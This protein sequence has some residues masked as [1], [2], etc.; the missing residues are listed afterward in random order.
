MFD[1]GNKNAKIRLSN[2][3]FYDSS[4]KSVDGTIGA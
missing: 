1:K 3:M 2:L 4:H